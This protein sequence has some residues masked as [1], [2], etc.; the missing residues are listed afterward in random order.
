[1]PCTN[2]VNAF[3]GSHVL[4]KLDSCSGAQSFNV[5]FQQDPSWPSPV[6]GFQTAIEYD[7]AV[8]SGPACDLDPQ[9]FF[10]DT[11]G[12]ECPGTY[13]GTTHYV[14]GGKANLFSDLWPPNNPNFILMNLNFENMSLAPGEMT[15]L[16]YYSSNA[17]MSTKVLAWYYY[18]VVELIDD[19]FEAYIT[20]S[21]G[22]IIVNKVSPFQ[23]VLSANTAEYDVDVFDTGDEKI[24]LI[25]IQACSTQGPC[26]DVAA[27][28]TLAETV[29]S[30]R[31][32]ENWKLPQ[33]FW[34]AL[35]NGKSYISMRATN[36]A[37]S[38]SAEEYVFF[39]DK[40]VAPMP[41]TGLV[42]LSS[43][44]G[45]EFIWNA[46]V[47]N[48]DGTGLSGLSG[49]H[50]Y[51]LRDCG[52]DTLYQQNQGLI[53]AT[54][55]YWTMTDSGIMPYNYFVVKAVNGQGQLSERSNCVTVITEPARTI[56][57]IVAEYDTTGGTLPGS[58]YPDKP[59][60]G[61][62]IKL[63]N[64]DVEMGQATTAADGTFTASVAEGATATLTIRVMIPGDSGYMYVPG[65][66]SGGTGYRD[67][68]RVTAAATGQTDA[69]TVRL[70]AG[71]QTG[72]FNC[73]GA[74]N[75]TD[76][77]LLKKPFGSIKGESAYN[78]DMD[79][80][81]DEIIDIKDFVLLKQTFGMESG[82]AV[83]ELCSSP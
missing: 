70:G 2:A 68:A 77:V 18:D 73:D 26:G 58:G 67:A 64:G 8:F 49:Y 6:G 33:A 65:S 37:G 50:V 82:A 1:M 44:Q 12:G 55:T 5:V 76:V 40:Q 31:F 59:V 46:P 30:S 57:G 14:F 23:S 54:S 62:T 51:S 9:N 25:E 47:Q 36:S 28:T 41:P 13:E 27:W 78:P 45:I 20:C 15:S 32:T 19:K 29:N 17:A 80:N 63:M 81:G 7:P 72:D 21:S 74:V 60:P 43:Q 75:I 53:P 24:Q 83:P 16:V 11:A 42:A 35:P 79:F 10:S 66:E 71:P 22:P 61:I 52:Q 38:F 3:D 39:V 4:I 69:G 34:N 48:T 56:T